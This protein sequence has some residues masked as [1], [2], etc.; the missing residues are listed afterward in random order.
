MAEELKE[1]GTQ[2]PQAEPQ[3]FNI[4]VGASTVKEDEEVVV[5]R[6]LRVRAGDIF[7]RLD[8]TID[9]VVLSVSNMTEAGLF[10]KIR[11]MAT[12]IE[13]FDL[14]WV[15]LS[16]YISENGLQKLNTIA[17]QLEDVD[18]VF[19]L[20]EGDVFTKDGEF[21][22]EILSN[23]VPFLSPI[24]ELRYMIGV[25]DSNGISYRDL[26]YVKSLILGQTDQYPAGAFMQQNVENTSKEEE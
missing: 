5:E 24:G 16:N 26:N 21:F 11:L 22:M 19:S 17:D 9:M 8:E 10:F 6:P 3:G 14:S 18:F 13:P 7:T 2:E 25:R 4:N 20:N 15:E 23:D 1:H 12:A